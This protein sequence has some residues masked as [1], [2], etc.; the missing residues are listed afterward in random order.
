LIS[1]TN[2]SG[3]KKFGG[4]ETKSLVKKTPLTIFSILFLI[5]L[6]KIL[7]DDVIKRFVISFVF[8]FF[9]KIVLYFV[10][11]YFFKKHPKKN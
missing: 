1:D 2:F 10:K 5:L 6:K 11:E 9:L 8:S 4:S 7:F 3:F